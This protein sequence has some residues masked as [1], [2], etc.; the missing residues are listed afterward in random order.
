MKNRIL[1]G[2]LCQH[3]CREDVEQKKLLVD[4]PMSD[5]G[6]WMYDKDAMWVN[7]LRSFTRVC[8]FINIFSQL[9]L[10]FFH[11]VVLRGEA[12]PMVL[13]PQ[14]NRSTLKNVLVKSQIQFS[15]TSLKKLAVNPSSSV[16][17]DESRDDDGLEMSR[18][19]VQT[20]NTPKATLIM[21]MTLRQRK[22]TRENVGR[23]R[24]D[25]TTVEE[26]SQRTCISLVI[27]NVPSKTCPMPATTS[28][29]GRTAPGPSCLSVLCR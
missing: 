16:D 10:T 20:L 5:V 9:I 2:D 14:D 8:T 24:P 13:D 4:A 25:H 7:V 21:E 26:T 19:W 22:A 6:G 11:I 28:S 17:G 15:G 29:W 12:E 3:G 18:E 23:W 1:P 27:S